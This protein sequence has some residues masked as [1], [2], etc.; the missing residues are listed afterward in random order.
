MARGSLVFSHVA[1]LTKGLQ[2][3]T[4]DPELAT[5]RTSDAKMR[6]REGFDAARLTGGYRDIQ[7]SLMIQTPVSSSRSLDQHIVEVQ[8]HLEL[9]FKLKTATGHRAYVMARNQRGL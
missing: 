5:L 4:S 6:L 7:L 2:L 9:L 3:I 1:D 8:L